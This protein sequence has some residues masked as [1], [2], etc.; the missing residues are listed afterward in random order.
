[1][2]RLSLILFVLIATLFLSVGFSAAQSLWNATSSS[3]YTTQKAFKSGD[4]VTILIVELTTAAHKAGTGTSFKDELSTKLSTSNI[5]ALSQLIG[6]GAKQL[7]GVGKNIYTGSG[8]TERTSQVQGK[9]A[10]IVDEVLSNG[11]LKVFGKHKVKINEETQ[12]IIVSGVVRPKDVTL[13][14]T[15]YSYQVAEA[16]IV[17]RGSGV[18]ESGAEPGWLT[19]MLNWLF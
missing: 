5:S 9:I 7:S 1:M 10:V 18:V 2:K 13:E 8:K 15:V 3:P 14:N 16:D 11:N 6:T 12:E 19:R 4:V 17:V